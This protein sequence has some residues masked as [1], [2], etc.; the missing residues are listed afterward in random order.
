MHLIGNRIVKI[1]GLE[2][3]VALEELYLSH[4]GLTDISG[5]AENVSPRSS[6]LSFESRM[7]ILSNH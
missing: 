6:I 7:L 2:T 4:N 5:L 3:L 1:E